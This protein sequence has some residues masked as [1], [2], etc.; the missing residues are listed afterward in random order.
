ME[1][2]HGGVT[3]IPRV[4]PILHY[5]THTCSC[6][7]PAH[8]ERVTGGHVQT[9]EIP[10]GCGE[11][12]L[13]SHRARWRG[14]HHPFSTFPHARCCAAGNL[15]R[16]R[17][18]PGKVRRHWRRGGRSAPVPRPAVSQPPRSEAPGQSTPGP[19]APLSGQRGPTYSAT[20]LLGTFGGPPRQNYTTILGP[21]F[22][23]VER[24]SNVR[25][26]K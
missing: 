12:A 18:R 2:C 17:S 24:V 10:A 21:V 16:G 13:A 4:K 7:T 23:L 5:I 22:Q 14:R 3:V 1:S 26:T 15:S 25:G 9:G 8:S 6:R 11:I 20:I 19:P